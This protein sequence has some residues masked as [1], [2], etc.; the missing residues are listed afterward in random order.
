M[1][2][3]LFLFAIRKEGKFQLVGHSIQCLLFQNADLST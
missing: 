1:S 2:A 3:I